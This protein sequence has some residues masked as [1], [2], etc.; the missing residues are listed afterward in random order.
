MYSVIKSDKFNFNATYLGDFYHKYTQFSLIKK[1]NF[2][3]IMEKL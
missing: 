3:F 2:Y 1:T